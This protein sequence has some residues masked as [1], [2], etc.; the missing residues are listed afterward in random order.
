MTQGLNVGSE[1]VFS[2]CP[3]GFWRFF[4]LYVNHRGTKRTVRGESSIKV[5]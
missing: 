5:S 2:P 4:S 1:Q 3:L